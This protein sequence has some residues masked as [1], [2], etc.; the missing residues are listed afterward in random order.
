MVLSL[1]I[2]I[3]RVLQNS[4]LEEASSHYSA[5]GRIGDNSDYAQAGT[6][7]S[8]LPGLLVTHIVCHGIC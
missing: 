3:D 8:I 4:N 1:N 6:S 5:I 7:E 2:F